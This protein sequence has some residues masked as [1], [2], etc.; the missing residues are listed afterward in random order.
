MGGRKKALQCNMYEKEIKYYKTLA[1]ECSEILPGAE[2]LCAIQ[3][4][5]EAKTY[6][7]LAMEDISTEYENMN[8]IQGLSVDDLNIVAKSAARLHA[9]YWE[10]DLLQKE[11]FL[12]I[13]NKD[14]KQ[15]CCWFDAW[16]MDFV[17]NPTQWRD[18]FPMIKNGTGVD[19]L[20]DPQWKALF[21]TV[22]ETHSMEL[23]DEFNK[24][25]DSRPKTL[26]HGDLRSDNIFRHRTDK[27]KF[28]YI[29]W[30]ALGAAP[31]GVE[32]VQMAHAALEPASEE[33]R[34]FE[35]IDAYLAELHAQNPAAKSYTREMLVQDFNMGMIMFTCM[36]VPTLTD[37]LK[38]QAP[39]SPL[40]QLLKP[41]CARMLV[42]SGKLGTAA[43]GL[44][45]AKEK[46]LID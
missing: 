4:R 46:G 20:G 12:K 8:Q 13:R 24:I 9:K 27:T 33:A 45:V 14:G 22:L 2:I 44:K 30:Q 37:I 29:D 21:E 34:I 43:Y 41:G 7:C 35:V 32:F 15:I 6:F 31:P 1:K 10:S 36:L 3:D 25:L 18:Y 40:W 28:K 39:D 16:T 11:E 42:C 38:P 26:L 19:I 17:A 23:F 5:K